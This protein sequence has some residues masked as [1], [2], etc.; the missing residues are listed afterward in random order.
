MPAIPLVQIISE[1]A[2]FI[3]L[4]LI[5]MFIVKNK[6]KGDSKF[7]KPEKYLPEDEIQNL[8]QA[9]YLILMAACF[10]N[11]MYPLIFVNQDLTYFT[12][13]DLILSLYISITIEKDTIWHKL[14]ILLL[15]PYG[16][17]TFL[18]YNNTLIGLLDL[19]HVPVFMY[20][21][22][23]Y[24]DKFDA[25]TE[26]HGLGITVLL[27]FTIIFLSF[28]ITAIVEN[29]NPLDSLVMVS[30]A[31]TSNGYAV[32]GNTIGGKINSIILVWSGFIISGV[33]TATL[34]SAILTRHINGKFKDYD[35]K[36]DELNG[37]ID[38]TNDKLDNLERLIKSNQDD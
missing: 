31:F 34:A 19:I 17:L 22:K 10:I 13:F 26:S 4:T 29:K 36:I 3:V 23:Y 37:K 2:L 33:G 9:T 21:I 15:V 1:I 35:E 14:I 5:G 20:F 24:Y 30:N 8:K 12:V 16:S 18:M 38:E 7:F 32:L 6:P 27:L 28:L 11:V 25:Y